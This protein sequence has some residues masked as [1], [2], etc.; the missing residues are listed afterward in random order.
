[1]ARVCQDRKGLRRRSTRAWGK[2]QNFRWV[3]MAKTKTS[4]S[5]LPLTSSSYNFSWAMGVSWA[6]LVTFHQKLDRFSKKKFA[7]D[8]FGGKL[9]TARTDTKMVSTC[10]LWAV[11]IGKVTGFGFLH[12]L[13]TWEAKNK[14]VRFDFTNFQ[15]KTLFLN[16]LC[17]L[18]SGEPVKP[19]QSEKMLGRLFLLRTRGRKQNKNRSR[20]R[21]VAS[22]NKNVL[23]VSWQ[24]PGK[25]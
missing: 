6:L 23:A 22:K 20:T 16:E 1:M 8:G 12:Q 2:S 7:N 25:P 19:H 14:K 21:S 9:K 5:L 17:G 13:R 11:G 15:S 24:C 3:S 4:F 10:A 18:A